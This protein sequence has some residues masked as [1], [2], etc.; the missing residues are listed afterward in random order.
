[1]K[2][3]KV[4]SM[5]KKDSVSRQGLVLSAVEE[6][7]VDLGLCAANLNRTVG[8]LGANL[9]VFTFVLA[10]FFPRYDASELNG[11]LLQITLVAGLLAIFLFVASGI[12][13]FEVM[14]FAILSVEGKKNLV[15]RGDSLFEVGLMISAAMPAFILFTLPGLL[16]VAVIAAVLWTL[17]AGFIL[18]R[19]RNLCHT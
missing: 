13:Y 12:S 7:M 3:G 15:R 2:L 16:V 17:C 18:R 6:G 11:L 10:F 1:M 14:A 8:V 4:T 19:G 9:T 5:S